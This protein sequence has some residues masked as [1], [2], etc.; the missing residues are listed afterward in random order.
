MLCEFVGFGSGVAKMSD[1]LEYDVAL[2]R[3]S[4]VTS[5]SEVEMF[6]D[7]STFLPL[8]RTSGADEPVTPHHVPEER[9]L[10]FGNRQLYFGAEASNLVTTSC[11]R[12]SFWVKVKLRQSLYISG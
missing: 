6:L 5:P 8:S 7:K 3:G 11:A 12:Q 2:L 1:V 4:A 10:V 9:K